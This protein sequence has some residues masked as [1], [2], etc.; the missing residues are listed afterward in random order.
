MI[1][2]RSE[3]QGPKTSRPKRKEKEPKCPKE[4]DA[5]TIANLDIP[6]VEYS[7]GFRSGILFIFAILMTFF[8]ECARGTEPFS[9]GLPTLSTGERGVA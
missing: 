5:E 6:R 9:F 3:T 1:L 7:D 2:S 8:E 4:Y